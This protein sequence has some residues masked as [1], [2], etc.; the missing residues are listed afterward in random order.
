MTQITDSYDCLSCPRKSYL[1]EHL[2]K[3]ELKKINDNRITVKFKHGD[4]IIK[5]GT[6]SVH[7]ITFNSGLAK[8]YL[9]GINNKNLIMDLVKPTQFIA[10]PGTFVDSRHHYSVSALE[11]CT[12]CFIDLKIFREILSQN[13]QFADILIIDISKNVISLYDKF[14]SLTQKHMPGR[15]ADAL[16]YLSEEIY[17]AN[18]FTL[19][20][21]RQEI[22]DLTA[23]SKE[24][25]IRIL[26]QFREEGIIKDERN[27]MEISNMAQ[28]EKISKLG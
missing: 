17:G 14:I 21:S 23:M 25:A 7:A 3:S 4:L 13:S 18:P 20:L 16:I 27:I 11:E 2:T 22:A 10:G 26:K 9:E 8:I 19:T 1:F 24:S 15:V 5:Q 28:L 6:A 12:V